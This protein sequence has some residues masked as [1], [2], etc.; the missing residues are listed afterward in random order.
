MWAMIKKLDKREMKRGERTCMSQFYLY[1]CS[2]GETKETTGADIRSGKSKMC[3][4]CSSKV[5]NTQ[6]LEMSDTGLYTSFRAMKSRA[7]ST[8]GHYKDIGMCS[9]WRDFDTFRK[10]AL[11]HGWEEGLT[12]DRR[13]NLGDYEPDNCRWL[14]RGDNATRANYA[15]PKGKIPYICVCE[16]NYKPKNGPIKYRVRIKGHKVSGKF[17]TPKE[18]AIAYNNY[19]IKHKLADRPLNEIW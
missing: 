11:K 13:D 14:T 12:I 18:A 9:E 19:V 3:R 5:N 6:R 2:C 15:A 1:E 10:W 7:D 16:D 8:E 17:D 4:A